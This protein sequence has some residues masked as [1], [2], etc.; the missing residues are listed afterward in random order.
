MRRNEQG[1]ALCE[2]SACLQF[3]KVDVTVK[4]VQILAARVAV[5]DR[6]AVKVDDVQLLNV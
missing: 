4:R 3:L 1:K 5:E 2:T 6:I